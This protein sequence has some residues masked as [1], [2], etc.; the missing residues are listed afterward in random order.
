MAIVCG[1]FKKSADSACCKYRVICSY[2]LVISI[3]VVTD[4]TS[5][6]EEDYA[7]EAAF[8]DFFRFPILPGDTLEIT[9]DPNPNAM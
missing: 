1:M 3:F 4:D 9:V 7:R 6:T 2:C 8:T 5:V